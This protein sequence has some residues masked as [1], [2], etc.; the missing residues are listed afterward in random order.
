MIIAFIV[1]FV[2]LA[3]KYSVVEAFMGT[4]G[5]AVIFYLGKWL[6]PLLLPIAW[7]IIAP[8]F[9]LIFIIGAA[10]IALRAIFR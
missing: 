3:I 8:W 1:L 4:I 5:Y 7:E 6:L 2:V 10:I 9:P